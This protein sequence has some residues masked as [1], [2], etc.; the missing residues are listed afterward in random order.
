[1]PGNSVERDYLPQ[2]YS[3]FIYAIIVEEIGLL[4]GIG[5]ILLYLILL[6]RAGR[7]AMQSPTVFPAIVVIGLSLMLVI[8]AF[9]NMAVA[10]SLGPVTGQP[11]PL[12]SRGGTAILITCI[13]FGVI[14]GVTRQIKEEGQ[15]DDSEM[16]DTPEERFR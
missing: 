2:A 13:Y 3:D 15:K 16:T 1:M 4:G 8:Q 7:I 14:L 9:V 5:V 6:Y 12:I 10:T 11:L